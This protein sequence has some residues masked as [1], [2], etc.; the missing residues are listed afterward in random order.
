MKIGSKVR[1]IG[2]P[3]KLPNNPD[4]P[5]KSV[6]ERCVG[7]EFVVAG[8]NELGMAE[9]RV[10]S[11]TGSVGETIWVETEFLELLSPH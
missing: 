10:E 5:T 7:H 4:L 8:F 2:I 6:F 1:L 11:V 3:P 9:L